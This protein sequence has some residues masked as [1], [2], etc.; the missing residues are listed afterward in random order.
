VRGIR[1]QQNKKEGDSFLSN[2]RIC[3]KNLPYSS[4]FFYPREREVD[5]ALA[6]VKLTGVTNCSHHGDKIYEVRC[7]AF[8]VRV[9]DDMTQ[10]AEVI[11]AVAVFPDIPRNIHRNHPDV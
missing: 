8:D 1:Y 7:N 4:V 6:E 2:C 5:H 11:P 9:C 10:Y 3:L